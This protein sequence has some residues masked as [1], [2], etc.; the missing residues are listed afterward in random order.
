MTES[1]K[2]KKKDVELALSKLMERNLVQFSKS[3]DQD[4][5]LSYEGK[6]MLYG[7]VERMMEAGLH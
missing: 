7:E 2:L 5:I 6:N 1:L 3:C 4:Y